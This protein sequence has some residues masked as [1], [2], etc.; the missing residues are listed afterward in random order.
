[1]SASLYE[2]MSFSWMSPIMAN[3][4]KKTLSNNDLWELPQKDQATVITKKYDLYRP[5]MS[6]GS[7]KLFMTCKKQIAIQLTYG[8][9]W[10]ITMFATPAFFY[11]LLDDLN[12]AHKHESHAWLYLTGLIASMIVSSI[13]NQLGN[14]TDYIQHPVQNNYFK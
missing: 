2:W 7:Y 12:N 11:F 8:L 14:M 10:S 5:D 3:G 9:L 1:M 4:A 6:F 13:C